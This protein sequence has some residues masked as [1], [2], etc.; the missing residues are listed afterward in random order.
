VADGVVT[1][2]DL[3]HVI[4]RSDGGPQADQGDPYILEIDT[5]VDEHHSQG[6]S[7]CEMDQA[8]WA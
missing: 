1:I 6:E 7:K 3:P 4:K 5:L 2:L 8:C